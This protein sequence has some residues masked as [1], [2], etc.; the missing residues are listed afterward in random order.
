VKTI[1]VDSNSGSRLEI[2]SNLAKVQESFPH[3]LL[4]FVRNAALPCT[5]ARVRGPRGAIGL[6]DLRQDWP[7]EST[8]YLR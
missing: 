8:K 6:M 3:P 7:G 1:E 5:I 4:V 2:F